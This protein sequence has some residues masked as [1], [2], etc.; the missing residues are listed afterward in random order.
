MMF[1]INIPEL[2]LKMYTFAYKINHLL[3]VQSELED[4][5]QY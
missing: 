3:Y 5:V 2:N 1:Y 4:E